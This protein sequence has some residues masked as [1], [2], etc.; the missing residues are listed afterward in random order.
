MFLRWR[1]NQPPAETVWAQRKRR[2]G[3]AR[4]AAQEV[5]GDLRSRRA[6][7]NSGTL[8][9]TKSQYF[10]FNPET[11]LA[12]KNISRMG[13][14]ARRRR[15]HSE[16][17]ITRNRRAHSAAWTRLHKIFLGVGGA[18]AVIIT[19]MKKVKD[20]KVKNKLVA[21]KQSFPRTA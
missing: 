13:N 15:F 7:A 18:K 16:I 8:T 14:R 3:L 1:R 19:A 6:R 11:L 20:E 21:V 9:E 10:A 4:A 5:L 17:R 12:A 2:E